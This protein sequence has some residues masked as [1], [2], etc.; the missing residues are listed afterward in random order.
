MLDHIGIDVSDF[1]ISKSLSPRRS[2]R[3]GSSR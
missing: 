2:P 1:A 3:L